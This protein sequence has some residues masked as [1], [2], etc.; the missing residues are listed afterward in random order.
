MVRVRVGSD[1]GL[2]VVELLDISFLNFLCLQL[3]ILS[4][5]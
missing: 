5:P 4:S 2:Q 3:C 1:G